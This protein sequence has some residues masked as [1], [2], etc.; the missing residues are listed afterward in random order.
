MRLY[1]EES[2]ELSDRLFVYISGGSNP[3][4]AGSTGS[5]LRLGNLRSVILPELLKKIV[6]LEQG[7]QGTRGA[8][9]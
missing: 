1:A 6:A 2:D 5:L 7:D 3:P 8:G 4:D 9:V